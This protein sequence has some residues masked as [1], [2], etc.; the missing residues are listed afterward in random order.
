MKTLVIYGSLRKQNTY[1]ITQHFLEAI[2]SE[3]EEVFLPTAL[4]KFCIGCGQ[5]F[6]EGEE[7]CPHREYVQPLEEKLLW[8]DLIIIT[9]PV[10]VLNVTGQVKTFLDH[11]AYMFLIHRPRP[12]MFT[13]QALIISTTAG[14]GTN[15]AINTIKDSLRYWGIGHIESFGTAVFATRWDDISEKR[16]GKIK[17][18]LQKKAKEIQNRVGNVTPQLKTKKL[19]Y[20]TR[21]LYR[22][23]FLPLPK[24]VAYWQEHDWIKSKKPWEVAE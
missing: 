6:L 19:F 23:H 12:E 2:D 13:K 20:Q 10:Y 22:K 14:A 1:H 7:L 3:I 5:C 17:Q 11:F 21:F 15:K 24:D 9:S 4:P 8:A 18:V 16:K